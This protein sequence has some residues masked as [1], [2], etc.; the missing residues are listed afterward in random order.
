M[1]WRGEG[2]ILTVSLENIGFDTAEVFFDQELPSGK[3]VSLKISDTGCG[4]APAVSSTASLSRFF[5]PRM[6][7]RARAWGWPWFMAS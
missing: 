4:I 5:Q 2:G 6:S 7:G 3:Y 1:P